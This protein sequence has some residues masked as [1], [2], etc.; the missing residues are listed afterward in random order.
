MILSNDQK[1]AERIRK[2]TG[3]L[4]EMRPGRRKGDPARATRLSGELEQLRAI[5]SRRVERSA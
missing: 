3:M 5:H 1:R 4:A 2:L